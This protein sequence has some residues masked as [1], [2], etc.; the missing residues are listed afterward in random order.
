[1]S[2]VGGEET[3]KSFE[4][5]DR[6]DNDEAEPEMVDSALSGG[7][8]K[9]SV[10]SLRSD[11]F[12]PLSEGNITN[13][14]MPPPP[15]TEG[16]FPSAFNFDDWLNSINIEELKFP[17]EE[18]YDSL[19]ADLNGGNSAEN[20]ERISSSSSMGR[21]SAEDGKN[22]AFK[23]P[24]MEALNSIYQPCNHLCY[25]NGFCT[26]PISGK[27]VM[28]LRNK[29]F[30]EE[31]I[32]APKDKERGE[33][34]MQYL[35][36]ARKD[37]DDNLIFV[38]DGHDV[39]TPSF[40]RILGVSSSPDITKAP[41]QW[42]RLIKGFLSHNSENLLSDKDLH[43]DAESDYSLKRG[44]V[45]AYINDVSQYFMDTLPTVPSEDG[46]TH[47]LQVPYGTIKAFFTEYEFHC[48][49]AGIGKSE[50]ASY[51]TFVRA[52]NDLHRDGVVVLLGG[53]GGMN[54]CSLCNNVTAI[55]RSLCCKRDLVTRDALMKLSRLHLEQQATE[56][57]HAENYIK[58][59]KNLG[60][61]GQ[62][63]RSYFDIDGQSVWTGNTPKY[64]KDRLSKVDCCIENRNIGVRMVCG[65]IDEYIAVCTDNLI[66]G[67]ANV[68]VEVVKYS[69]EHLGRRL[70]EFD[71]VTPKTVGL[72]FDNSGENK[73]CCYLDS[74]KICRLYN[75][76]VSLAN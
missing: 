29:Y 16:E 49:A 41:G 17:N 76:M 37:R 42:N 20:S 25:L 3:T 18:I 6:C 27:A 4:S 74:Y 31:G 51:Q 46:A 65:P 61:D 7:S 66:P 22:T 72:Q 15:S 57:Q 52:F 47:A 67:G 34:I 50:R 9:T 53:K 48:T 19:V 75:Y 8:S 26:K 14:F 73:V 23:T 63:I 35:R 32:E 12:M 5:M 68:L 36:T 39:C 69:M 71:M 11:D 30:F 44:H 1:M 64:S 10:P 56:R 38:V 59:A 2:K 70:S 45:K 28:D 33:I 40:L 24:I 55:K 60:P 43:I 21:K 54:T 62:P 13:S 58:I